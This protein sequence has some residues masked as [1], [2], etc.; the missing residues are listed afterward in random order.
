MSLHCWWLLRSFPVWGYFSNAA[1]AF[2]AMSFGAQVYTVCWVCVREELRSLGH[3][4]F[5]SILN[6]IPMFKHW[7]LLSSD[8]SPKVGSCGMMGWL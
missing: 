5:F 6:C 1:R 2:W 4:E 3:T 7:Q 8:V